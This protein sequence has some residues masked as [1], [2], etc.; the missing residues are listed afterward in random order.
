MKLFELA[1][2]LDTNSMERAGKIISMHTSDR[3]VWD[4][5]EPFPKIAADVS[6]V[7]VRGDLTRIRAVCDPDA[8]VFTAYILCGPGKQ[9]VF[10]FRAEDNIFAIL[11]PLADD[12]G[13]WLPWQ[14]PE[15]PK[16]VKQPIP[17]VCP[18]CGDAG[19]WRMMAL[20][21]RRGHGVFQG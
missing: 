17:E 14:K 13:A 18:R 9:K 1:R 20:V 11:D 3:S 7:V 19:E 8:T 21:C 15:P 12:E 2:T 6:G 4:F 16:P 10:N 5:L